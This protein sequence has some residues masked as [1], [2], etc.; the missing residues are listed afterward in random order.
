LQHTFSWTMGKGKES[1][2]RGA[3]CGGRQSADIPQTF[4]RQSA[5]T[6]GTV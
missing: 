3:G 4:N 5:D 2:Q 6:L 1:N